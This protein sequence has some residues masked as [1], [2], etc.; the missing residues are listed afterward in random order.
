[1]VKMQGRDSINIKPLSLCQRILR[2]V[3]TTTLESTIAVLEGILIFHYND[4]KKVSTEYLSLSSFVVGVLI[5]FVSIAVGNMS[6]RS[7][8][9]YRRKTYIMFFAPLYALGTFFRFGA[10]TSDKSA[11]LYYAIT[12]AVQ[13]VGR[14]GMGITNDAWNME[15]ANEEVDRSKLYATL[16]ATGVVG[17]LM[18]LGLTA[19]PLVYSG[20]LL[21]IL[22]VVIN[23]ANLVMIPEGTPMSKRCFIPTGK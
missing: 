15:L 17:I 3:A 22:V 20:T 23:V 19:V 16:T 18:G 13:I 12:L 8:G 6:D 7:K 9:K 10:F 11:A 1:V 4:K 2:G 5:V 21:S 14:S